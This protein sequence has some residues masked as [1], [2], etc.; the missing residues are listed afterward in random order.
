MIAL[1]IARNY[2]RDKMQQRVAAFQ[3]DTQIEH[4]GNTAARAH[5]AIHDQHNCVG[6]ISV[7]RAIDS[8]LQK[9]T[10]MT[11]KQAHNCIIL[12]TPVFTF[13]EHESLLLP[14]LAYFALRQARILGC[15][16]VIIATHHHPLDQQLIQLLKLEPISHLPS[17]HAQRLEYAIHSAYEQCDVSQ[18]EFIQS[19]F[20]H[21]ILDSFEIWLTTLFQDSWFTAIKTQT[22]S[23]EQYI[24]SLFNLHQF[25]KHTTRLAARCVAMC[26]NRDLRNHYIYHLKGEVNHEV[27][28][29]SDLR[30]LRADVNYLLNSHVPHTATAGF[31]VLQESI[32]GFKRD[33]VLMLACPFIA[34][35]MTANIGYDFVE[36]LFATIRNWGIKSPE[37]VSR[38]LTSHMKTDGGD[39]GHWIRVINRIDEFVHTE[40]QMQ[41]FINMLRLAMSSYAHGL[42][43]NIDDLELWRADAK[44]EV[45]A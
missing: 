24:A 13:E 11:N 28:I 40:N 12:H 20:I 41:E 9:S 32:T 27:I 19:Y 44:I 43:A 17:L 31:M 37:S 38:F 21:E 18:R 29:E 30:A 5:I 1:Q 10:G 8:V 22:I 35:G 2:L 34:E 36:N 23:K 4:T 25:V 16:N 26:E 39:D 33:A 6:K 3:L 45:M 15:Q 42:N 14:M 7:E